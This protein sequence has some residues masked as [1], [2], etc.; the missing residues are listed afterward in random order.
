M[1][2]IK[3]KYIH[4]NKF[5]LLSNS[6][7]KTTALIFSDRGNFICKIY[8]LKYL[9]HYYR[10]STIYKLNLHEITPVLFHAKFD[11]DFGIIIYR[12]IDSSGVK[13]YNLSDLYKISDKANEFHKTKI[14]RKI[15]HFI[16][17]LYSIKEKCL[18]RGN[19]Q[20]VDFLN[21][22]LSYFECYEPT[23]VIHGDLFF[24]NTIISNNN[25]FLIDFE[26]SMVGPSSWDY[27]KLLT[28]ANTKNREMG[29]I[30]KNHLLDVGYI[31]SSESVFRREIEMFNEYRNIISIVS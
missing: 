2:R 20:F 11:G 6:E 27:Y 25:V 8:T 12:H 18:V 15:D 26:W 30:L 21:K 9:D 3:E 24:K 14:T 17:Q 4:F 16:L 22:M 31:K 29:A 7:N 5:N 1:K 28:S 13:G 23:C 10:E 19:R